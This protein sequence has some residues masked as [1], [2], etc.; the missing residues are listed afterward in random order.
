VGIILEDSQLFLAVENIRMNI[1]LA[2]ADLTQR[3]NFFCFSLYRYGSGPFVL[4]VVREFQKYFNLD[5]H[6]RMVSHSA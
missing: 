6:L 1:P 5:S 4:G 2:I 3:L